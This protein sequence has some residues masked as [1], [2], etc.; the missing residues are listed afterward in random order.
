MALDWRISSQNLEALKRTDSAA[1]A[2]VR[3]AG[4]LLVLSRRHRR[5]EIDST[6]T[7]DAAIEK[8]FM[9]TEA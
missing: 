5:V 9:R 4:W 1:V 6:E 7:S 2:P 8:D 3:R